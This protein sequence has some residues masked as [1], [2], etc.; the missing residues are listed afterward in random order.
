[1]I[2]TIVIAVAL[3]T[4]VPPDVELPQEVEVAQE[5]EWNGEVLNPVN[6]VVYGQSGIET[7]YNLDMTYVVELMRA[8]GY[9]EE[10]YPY[11][12][13]ED[14]VK[15]FGEYVMCAADWSIRPK[16][17]ILP[18]TLGEAIVVDTGTFIYSNPTQLD[19][20]VAW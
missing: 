10:E 15:M 17:T 3:A 6:G 8:E 14:G 1:M 4:A 13:R 16:G 19:I 11:W 9:S 18:T 20:A 2:A 7:Y 5:C 12:I